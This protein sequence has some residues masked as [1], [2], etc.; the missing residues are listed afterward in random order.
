MYFVIENHKFY[1]LFWF[2]FQQNMELCCNSNSVFSKIKKYRLLQWFLCP[3]Y[4]VD[5][6]QYYNMMKWIVILFLEFFTMYSKVQILVVWNNHEIGVLTNGKVKCAKNLSKNHECMH[7]KCKFLV[8]VL[9]N[10]FVGIKFTS[11]SMALLN[12]VHE[13]SHN[14]L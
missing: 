11:T 8:I 9:W 1:L 6:L 14:D 2:H 12:D 4:C 5:L 3:D 7:V 10:N 13:L